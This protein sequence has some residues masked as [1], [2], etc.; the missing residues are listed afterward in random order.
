MKIS[1]IKLDNYRRK[2][3]NLDNSKLH[4]LFIKYNEIV[5][6]LEISFPYLLHN[7]IKYPIPSD[8]NTKDYKKAKSILNLIKDEL[9]IRE[10]EWEPIK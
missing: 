8:D 2:I 10:H 1:K 6:N 3:K 4:K 5:L 9:Y 7:S